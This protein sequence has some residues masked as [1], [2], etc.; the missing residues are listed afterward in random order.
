MASVEEY[1][2]WKVVRLCPANPDK[3]GLS[4]LVPGCGFYSRLT[5]AHTVVILRRMQ[6]S[7]FSRP[8]LFIGSSKESL[9]Y[10]YAIQENLEEDAEVTVW[11]Q[12]IFELTK[13]SAES[14][15]KALTR[16]DFAIF[17]F[18]PN[19]T[20]RL[21]KNSYRAV[22]DNVVFE[23]GLFM[24]KL[25]RDH[26]FMVVPKGISDLRIPTDLAGLT[27]GRFDPNRKDKN[28][29]AAFG[30]FCNDVRRQLRRKP[31]RTKS[32][33]SKRDSREGDLLIIEALYGIRDHQYDVTRQLN[34]AITDGKLHLYVGNQLA[35]DPA[36]NT[37]KEIVVK[38]RVKDQ[39]LE[40]VVA[41]G[42]DLD[43][44]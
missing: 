1:Y 5:S 7:N 43:I 40:K 36:P 10:A 13:S 25:G 23:L 20:V 15:I 30:P 31:R 33:S 35:G 17:V 2:H 37:P 19:D 41:E 8:R 9:D 6:K 4:D 3:V 42:Q 28:L 32:A 22:R 29:Q 38:Y 21:R 12:G 44:P 11:T 18:A 24:G 39:V 14:L 34:N 16:F 27:P 26:T